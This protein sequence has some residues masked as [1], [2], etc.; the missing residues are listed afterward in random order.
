MKTIRNIFRAIAI[1]V[2]ITAL[3]SCSDDGPDYGKMRVSRMYIAGAKAVGFIASSTGSRGEALSS[4]LY[5]I[6]ANGNISAVAVYFT[7]DEEGNQT[8]HESEVK[9]KYAK[10]ANAGNDYIYFSNCQ[11]FDNNEDYISGLPRKILV[12]KTDGK[13]WNLDEKYTGID[14]SY[15]YDDGDGLQPWQFYQDYSGTLYYADQV[16]R[17]K[18]GNIYKFNLKTEPATIEQVTANVELDSPYSVDSQ[19]IIFGPTNYYACDGKFVW[20]NS[21]FQ[22]F[23]N[24]EL[25][26]IKTD[27]SDIL[28]GLTVSLGRSYGYERVV[29]F[30][31][32]YYLIRDIDY[33]SWELNGKYVSHPNYPFAEMGTCNKF[34]IGSVPGSAAVD[35]SE[36]INIK[37]DVGDS[38]GYE[39]ESVMVTP[40]WILTSGRTGRYYGHTK[41]WITALNPEKKEWKWVCETP[42]CIDF[43]SSLSYNDCY[44]IIDTSSDNLGAFWFHPGSLES[45]F[46]KFATTLPSYMNSSKYE[47]VDGKV[48]FSGINPADSHKV[49]IVIDLTTG[50][51]VTND[52]AP[53]MLF[54]TLISLN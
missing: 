37:N 40:Q 3:N 8:K 48:I 45:G 47:V 50:S 23:K 29:N 39:M 53:E 41:N 4:G 30:R 51:A 38:F 28:D 52:D 5:K 43:T 17:W 34:S 15:A 54:S 42:Y 9:L 35:M 24:I 46:V 49:K 44:W 36:T 6:D 11:F 27:Y 19:G 21:G 31:G 25:P 12:R 1:I 22:D 14:F 13:M 2:G 26:P 16:N 7:E 10:M 32:Q 18:V 20:Q 33:R